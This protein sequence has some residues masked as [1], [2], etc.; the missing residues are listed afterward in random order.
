MRSRWKSL[1]F[2]CSVCHPPFCS[3]LAFIS[4]GFPL[5]FKP[6][7]IRILLF[8]CFVIYRSLSDSLH[9]DPVDCIHTILMWHSPGRP[10]GALP[11]LLRGSS[12]PGIKPGSPALRRQVLLRWSAGGLAASSPARIAVFRPARI[13]T[14]PYMVASVCPLAA[15]VFAVLAFLSFLCQFPLVCWVDH[16]NV[17]CSQHICLYQAFSLCTL[18]ATRS[19]L[20]SAAP[21]FHTLP[22]CS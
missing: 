6:W 7:Y 1:S 2:V 14:D 15:L 21:Q 4:C 20:A 19:S 5:L 17:Y 8:S 13:H 11:F 9:D 3:F 18:A 10:A 16:S 22:F 12:N